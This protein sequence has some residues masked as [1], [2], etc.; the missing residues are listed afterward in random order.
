MRW[1]IMY[2]LNL[3]YLRI[4]N[5][6]PDFVSTLAKYGRKFINRKKSRFKIDEPKNSLGGLQC[7]GRY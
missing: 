2:M 4:V 1:P 5:V 3:Q 7:N 6:Q